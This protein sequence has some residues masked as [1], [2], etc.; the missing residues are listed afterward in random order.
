MLVVFWE[1]NLSLPKKKLGK[2][3]INEWQKRTGITSRI[4]FRFMKKSLVIKGKRGMETYKVKQ[5]IFHYDEETV[6]KIRILIIDAKAIFI[7]TQ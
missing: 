4:P 1:N 2:M 6:E 5:R 7:H 3:L